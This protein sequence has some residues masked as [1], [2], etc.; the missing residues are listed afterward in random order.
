MNNPNKPIS[1]IALILSLIAIFLSQ[2]GPIYLQ[3][4]KENM[5]AEINT[6][7]DLFIG[8][9]FGKIGIKPY[10]NINNIGGKDGM[11]NKVTFFLQKEDTSFQT[12]LPVQTYDMKPNVNL[13]NQNITQIPF[14]NI[15]IE[16]NSVWSTFLNA[17]MISDIEKQKYAM[18]LVARVQQITALISKDKSQYYKYMAIQ[19]SVINKIDQFITANIKAFTKGEYFLQMVLWGEDNTKPLKIKTYK[20]TVYEADVKKISLIYSEYRKLYFNQPFVMCSGFNARL[21][22]VNDP[23]LT[24]KMYLKSISSYNSSE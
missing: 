19:D 17:Y 8:Q 9:N 24:N 2:T 23:N 4:G 15:I 13:P 1:I 20:F 7:F 16:S 21:K 11:V 22:A 5:D 18:E 14:N 10:V 3:F 12:M 6:D